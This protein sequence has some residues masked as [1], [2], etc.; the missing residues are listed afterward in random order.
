MLTTASQ[1]I[2]PLSALENCGGC[3]FGGIAQGVD[4]T[5]LSNVDGVECVR[6]AC[7][8]RKSYDLKQDDRVCA[9]L[10]DSCAKGTKYHSGTNSCT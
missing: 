1:C 3:S 4:C 10:Q 7:V 5:A 2:D 6:G 8:I 9:D